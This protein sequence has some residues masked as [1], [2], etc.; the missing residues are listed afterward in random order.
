MSRLGLLNTQ[1]RAT[2]MCTLSCCG[3]ICRKIRESFPVPSGDNRRSMSPTVG[4][5]MSKNKAAINRWR[6]CAGSARASDT[7]KPKLNYL[8]LSIAE[9]PPFAGAVPF[10]AN[11]GGESLLRGR[12]LSLSHERQVLHEPLVLRGQRPGFHQGWPDV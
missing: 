7:L 2:P 3:T 11:A 1:L 12:D 4:C 5:G 9:Y 10:C 8:P 6:I